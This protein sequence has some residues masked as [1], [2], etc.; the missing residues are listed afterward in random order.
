[1]SRCG[2][3]ETGVLRQARPHISRD[4]VRPGAGQRSPQLRTS[5]FDP[6][7]PRPSW[8]AWSVPSLRLGRADERRRLRA[9][10]HGRA[11]PGPRPPA[12]AAR[13]AG[14]PR[15]EGRRPGGGHGRGAARGAGGRC[16]GARGRGEQRRGGSGGRDRAAGDAVETGR[17][18]RRWHRRWPAG[19]SSRAS[20]P[21]A[22]TPGARTGCGPEGSAAE[23]VASCCRTARSPPLSTT[24]RPP[25]WRTW[26][27]TCRG[28]RPRLRGRCRRPCAGGRPRRRGDR[29]PRSGRRRAAAGAGARAVHRGADRGRT[30]GTRPGPAC[31]SPTWTSARE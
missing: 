5:R 19:W 22:S 17:A 18:S 11:G 12:G 8:Q 3:A 25:A 20:T 23:Q 29:P 31:C 26:T 16:G 14:R 10:W 15:I 28:G 4:L 27:R 13:S 6:T 2:P 9:G 7:M 24:S 30:G 21:W 1:M